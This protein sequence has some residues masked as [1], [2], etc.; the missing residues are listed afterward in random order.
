MVWLK[1]KYEHFQLFKSATNK[2]LILS[3]SFTA[4]KSAHNRLLFYLTK[5]NSYASTVLV[6]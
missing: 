5:K 4:I 2:V 1:Y 6:R 3:A